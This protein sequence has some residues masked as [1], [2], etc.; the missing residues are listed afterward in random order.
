MK[1]K[2]KKIYFNVNEV[3]RINHLT[4]LNDILNTI[5]SEKYYI[6]VYNKKKG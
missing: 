2:K 4:T 5:N 3:K 1:K 6:I